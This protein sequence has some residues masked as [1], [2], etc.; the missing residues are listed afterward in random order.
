MIVLEVCLYLYCHSSTYHEPRKDQHLGRRGA[1]H[2]PLWWI[3]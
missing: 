2:I 3:L 1:E